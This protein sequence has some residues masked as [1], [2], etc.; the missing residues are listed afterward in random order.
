MSIREWATHTNASGTQPCCNLAGYRQEA[1]KI[2][3]EYH[4]FRSKI[5]QLMLLYASV[6]MIG[7]WHAASAAAKES[8]VHHGTFDTFNG[9]LRHSFSPIIMVSV[10][11][12]ALATCYPPPEQHPLQTLAFKCQAHGSRA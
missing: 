4:S 3:Q 6:L 2:K 1:L 9:V 7:M 5:A 10:Q 12:C 11:A 8:Q